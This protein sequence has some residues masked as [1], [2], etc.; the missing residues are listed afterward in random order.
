M[1]LTLAFFIRNLLFDI[2]FSFSLF[3]ELHTYLLLLSHDRWWYVVSKQ[4]WLNF[5]LFAFHFIIRNLIFG[6]DFSFSP[7]AE[8]HTYWLTV[9]F[10]WLMMMMAAVSWD[11][12]YA[13]FACSA[14]LSSVMESQGFMCVFVYLVEP[15]PASPSAEAITLGWGHFC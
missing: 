3:S 2:D 1:L 8:L 5:D 13:A 7:F 10:T 9:A 6:I 12:Y 14:L 11:Y 4:I 15:T